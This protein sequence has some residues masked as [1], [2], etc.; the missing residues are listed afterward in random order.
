MDLQ[1]GEAV[2]DR[3][4]KEAA[5]VAAVGAL[6]KDF[7]SLGARL[8]ATVSSVEALDVK[9]ADANSELLSTA[10]SVRAALKELQQELDTLSRS[11]E[12]RVRAQIHDATTQYEGLV[13]SE[14]RSG[15]QAQRQAEIGGQVAFVYLVEH[16]QA[17]TG[18]L[19][20]ALQT[21]GEDALGDNLDSGGGA[22]PPLIAGLVADQVAHLPAHQ[23]GHPSPGSAGCQSPG[24]QHDDA[25]TL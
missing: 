16:H 15:V 21:T 20:V 17:D 18:Q 9:L 1:R 12:A 19:R 14:V 22:D 25:S 24:F 6:K 5:N 7:E 2:L 11:I 13:R 8:V 23:V 4:E 3:L 10:E